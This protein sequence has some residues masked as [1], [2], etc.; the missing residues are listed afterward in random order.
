MRQQV[1]VE[2]LE[3][4]LHR[5]QRIE[6]ALSQ[7]RRRRR[8]EAQ[9]LGEN[10]LLEQRGPRGEA[11]GE[12]D[13]D[14]AD[15]REKPARAERADDGAQHEVA[16]ANVERERRAGLAGGAVRKPQQ[17]MPPLQRRRAAQ[18][19]PLGETRRV[20]ADLDVHRHAGPVGEQ[21]LLH[22]LHLLLEELGVVVDHERLARFRVGPARERKRRR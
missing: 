15:G 19:H 1:R 14:V 6:Q 3:L 5:L 12:V 18:A 8:I 16:V 11:V 22:I 17:Q 7:P 13:V 20:R 4:H 21:S 10:L 2:G 9:Q